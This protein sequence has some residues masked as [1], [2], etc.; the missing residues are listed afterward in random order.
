MIKN[1]LFICKHNVFRS[2]YA[3][4]YFKKLN[5]NPSTKVKS[6]G[7]IKRNHLDKNQVNI[8]KQR[9]IKLKGIPTKI[10]KKLLNWQDTI[11]IAADDVPPEIFKDYKRYIKRLIIWKIPDNTNGNKKEIKKIMILIEKRVKSFIKSLQ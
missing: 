7:I 8:A 2:R 4:A 5:K 6:A 3:E 1:T 10:N 11:I 9:G